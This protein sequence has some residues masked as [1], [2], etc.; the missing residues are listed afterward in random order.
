MPDLEPT[1]TYRP[2]YYVRKRDGRRVKAGDWSDGTVS[3][4]LDPLAIVWHGYAAGTC[5]AQTFERNHIRVE[6]N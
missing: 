4:I 5:S 3:W 6:S 2:D 1:L